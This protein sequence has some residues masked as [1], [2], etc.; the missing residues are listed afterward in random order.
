MSPSDRCDEVIRLID[1]VL[2]DD[3]SP[4]EE[5][6]VSGDEELDDRV[7]PLPG[8]WGVHYLKPSV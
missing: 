1:A 5:V 2:A 7:E 8:H 4:A 3:L 6:R